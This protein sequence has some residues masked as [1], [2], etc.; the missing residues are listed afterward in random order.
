MFALGLM[1]VF[2]KCSVIG[3]AVSVLKRL[4]EF[5]FFLCLEIFLPRSFRFPKSSELRGSSHL[6]RQLLRIRKRFIHIYLIQDIF[7][8][9]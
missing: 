7:L 1:M 4:S 3:R 9:C 2:F 5:R 6:L 8:V